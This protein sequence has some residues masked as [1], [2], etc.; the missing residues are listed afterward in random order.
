VKRLITICVVVG[1]LLITN[2]TVANPTYVETVDVYEVL[3]TG[4]SSAPIDWTHTYDGS[5]DPIAW[6]TLTI[7][8]EGVDGPAPGG[9]PDGEDDMVYFDGHFLGYLTQQDFYNPGLEINPGPGALG[10]P[11]TELTT[12]VF[13]LDPSWIVPSMPTA[14]WV[15]GGNWIMEVET[16]TLTVTPIP[17]PGAI[18][19]GGIGV[20]LVGWLR[21]RRTL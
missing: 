16:S 8:A 9:S 7:V 21:R 10:A 5:A 19:L 1:L 18:L 15:E 20:A 4:G 11:Y 12:S 3:Q 2:T 17:A 14:V 13:N 6:A